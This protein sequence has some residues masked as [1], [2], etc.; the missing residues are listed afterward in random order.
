M[1]DRNQM[2]ARAAK[3][4]KNGSKTITKPGVFKN[5]AKISNPCKGYVYWD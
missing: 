2:A 3:E 4:I 5:K 1:W